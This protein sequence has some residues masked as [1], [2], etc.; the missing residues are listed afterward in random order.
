MDAE[1]EILPPYTDTAY[2]SDEKHVSFVDQEIVETINN[3]IDELS[4]ALR[5]LSLKIHGK[6]YFLA[7]YLI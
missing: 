5:E 4:P 3:R 1:Q 2:T 6:A 7:H